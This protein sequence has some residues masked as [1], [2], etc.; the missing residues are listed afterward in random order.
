MNINSDDL[1]EIKAILRDKFF[2]LDVKITT[3]GDFDG[4][5][6]SQKDKIGRLLNKLEQNK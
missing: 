1:S 6:T 5:W 4:Y 2:E 3:I